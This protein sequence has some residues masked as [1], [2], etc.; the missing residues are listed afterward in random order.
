MKNGKKSGLYVAVLVALGVVAAPTFAASQR[1]PGSVGDLLMGIASAK[2]LKATNATT[3]EAAL[4]ASGYDLPQLDRTKVLTE[5]DVAAIANAV[6]LPVVSSNPARSFSRLQ[7]DRF[8]TSMNSELTSTRGRL[9]KDDVTNKDSD[10]G[11]GKKPR[12][13]SPKRR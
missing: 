13:K 6:G 10:S 4:R 9:R 8:L 2:S 7:V 11:S 3:A 12:S 5:G 1:D